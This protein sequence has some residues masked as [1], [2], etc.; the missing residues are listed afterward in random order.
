MDFRQ[1]FICHKA[2]F[3]KTYQSWT[4]RKREYVAHFMAEEYAADKE[5]TR[6]LLYGAWPARYEPPKETP[7]S[8]R[9]SRKPSRADKSRKKTRK[10]EPYKP[11]K[12]DF[13]NPWGE[14]LIKDG[15]YYVRQ[16]KKHRRG[17][18][19]GSPL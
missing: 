13:H 15:M 11:V 14:A 7:K 19:G 1:L 16:R 10:P 6:E 5:G 4:D 2:L 9:S 17:G 12:Q 3:Y 8:K 18:G